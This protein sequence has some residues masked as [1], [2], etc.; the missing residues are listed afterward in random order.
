MQ[1]TRNNILKALV[2]IAIMIL[3]IGIS[4]TQATYNIEDI[5]KREYWTWHTRTT[6][7]DKA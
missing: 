1:K 4:K 2:I 7:D 5:F 3:T 6:T